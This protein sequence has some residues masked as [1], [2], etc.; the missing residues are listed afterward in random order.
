MF[1]VVAFLEKPQPALQQD[2]RAH[3]WF[4]EMFALN[5]YSLSE[6]HTAASYLSILEGIRARKYFSVAPPESEIEGL[7]VDNFCSLCVC[8]CLPLSDILT[9]SKTP[10]ML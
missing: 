3:P 10:E 7:Y 9:E 4:L 1:L 5:R 6:V 2:S 8:V